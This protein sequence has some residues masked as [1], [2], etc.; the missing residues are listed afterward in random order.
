MKYSELELEEDHPYSRIEIIDHGL[1]LANDARKK[2][3]EKFALVL[4]EFEMEDD[5]LIFGPKW[6]IL[7]ESNKDI[8]DDYVF[9]GYFN[10]TKEEYDI[11]VNSKKYNL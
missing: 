8:L 10:T 6:S 7:P 2:Y 1:G 9:V 11:Y 4:L 5:K 3:K